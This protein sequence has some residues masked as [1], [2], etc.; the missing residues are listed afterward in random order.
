M[1][2][3][4]EM[5]SQMPAAA[6]LDG[7]ELVPLVQAGGNVQASAAAVSKSGFL[8]G[9]S[10]VV[11]R[12]APLVVNAN[13]A[14][15]AVDMAT[16]IHYIGTDSFQTKVLY[17]GFGTNGF[18]NI[19]GRVA[20]GTESAP[21]ANAVNTKIIQMHG[22]GYNGSGYTTAIGSIILQ[23]QENFTP[24]AN[25]TQWLIS[26]T[27]TGGTSQIGAL[28]AIGIAGLGYAPVTFGSLTAA[29]GGA[30]GTIVPG[31]NASIQTQG[32]AGILT[33]VLNVGTVA[34]GGL[35]NAVGAVLSSGSLQASTTYANDAAAAIGGIAI[36]QFYRNGSVVQIRIS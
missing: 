20:G 7:T 31:S 29:F 23:A 17:D 24:S 16:L 6:T 3:S 1:S 4:I 14:V 19:A 32:G 11:R 13:T 34:G 9:G 22:T 12:G 25:G 10:I 2:A 5:I 30:A 18:V 8:N 33:D 36:G 15:P 21:T 26:V 27:P 28:A 35:F